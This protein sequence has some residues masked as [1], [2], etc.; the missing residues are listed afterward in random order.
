MW[1]LTKQYFIDVWTYLWSKTT[2]DDIFLAKAAEVKAKAKEIKEV[3]K[4]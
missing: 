1:K 2:V 3:I 4:K